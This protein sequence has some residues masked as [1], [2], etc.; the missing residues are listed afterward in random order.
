MDMKQSEW[1]EF[2]DLPGLSSGEAA[3][4]A[5]EGKSNRYQGVRTPSVGRI[6]VRN[7]FSL[8]HLLM[9][10]LATAVF[11]AGSPR[12]AL[13]LGVIVSNAAIGIFQELRAKRAADRLNL[14][15]A[16]RVAV[17]RDGGEKQIVPEEIVLGDLLLC[18]TG[19]QLPVDARVVRG[20]A[21]VNE[22][23]LTG[24]SEPVEKA[25]GDALL[26]GSFLT[27]GRCAA[28]VTAVNAGVYAARITD[29]AKKIKRPTSEI[30]RSLN[31]ILKIGMVLI[32]FL[33]GGLFLKQIL[34]GQTAGDAV[35][36]AVASMLGMIPSGLILLSTVVYAAGVT[37]LAR[38]KVTVS[39][40]NAIETLARVDVLCLDKTGT[41]TEG[42][43]R[44]AG[45]F[46]IGRSREEAEELLRRFAALSPDSNGTAEALRRAFPGE[47]ENGG[48]TIP[49]S[50][51]HR[52]S[53][54]SDGEGAL[55]LGAPET[56]L[57][58]QAE[59]CGE[60]LSSLHEEGMRVVALA[61][62]KELPERAE[63]PE[64]LEPAALIALEDP[65]RETAEETFRAFRE[66]GVEIKLISGDDAK[67]A[68]AVA[69]KAGIP[70]KGSV[71][72]TGIES[73]D[74]EFVGNNTVFGRVTPEKKCEILQKLRQKHVT[75]MVGDGVNDVL[76]LHEADVGAAMASGSSAA[77]NKAEL[78]LLDS[79]PKALLDAVEEGRRAI[80]S[81][82]RTSTLYLAKTI[83]TLLLTV[84][85]LFFSDTYPFQPIHMTLI[86]AVTIGIPSVFLGL[87]RNEGP[88]RGRFLA[89]VMRTTLP[90]ALLSLAAMSAGHF[91]G[92]LLG[93][94]PGEISTMTT[95]AAVIAGLTVVWGLARPFTCRHA[96]LLAAL[97]AIFLG[98]AFL[99]PGFFLLAPLPS[100]AVLLLAAVGVCSVICHPLLCRLFRRLLPVE[101]KR[102]RN[103][104]KA[105]P[106]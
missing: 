60:R 47:R 38:R 75:A 63:I 83:Y 92:K 43:M 100:S 104:K 99:F 88:V 50:S 31:L 91:G 77:R 37:R 2:S 35:V 23:F 25:A 78:I 72:M 54:V 93:L 97:A 41:V 57:R 26:S 81:V 70:V 17:I 6:V 32:P 85:V 71:D 24:E 22:S 53:A 58:K 73:F 40:H 49:F 46:P 8:F 90:A 66:A 74:A 5:A 27:A 20:E 94:S 95:A 14:L 33:G 56:V 59:A 62:G 4:R 64:G 42:S 103:D 18:R 1:R 65:V 52:F 102:S 82:E 11:L 30:R 15:S 68:E 96:L 105:R 10:G 86:G 80:R 19:D 13:F 79:D 55:F 9:A 106:V 34:A 44:V 45:V 21:E 98:A 28:E 48:R 3:A 12:N 61:L 84:L 67:T 87:E 51:R 39:E 36:A 7:V 101:K 76:A 89:N 16:R 29:R 69:K